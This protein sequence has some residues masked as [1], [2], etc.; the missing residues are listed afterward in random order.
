MST[1]NRNENFKNNSSKIIGIQFSILSPEEIKKGSVA[2]IT[3]RDTYINNKP[4]IGGLFDP[5]MG[6]IEPNLICPTDGLDYMQTPGYF[7]HIDLARPVFY[8][9]YLN[10]VIK[11]LRCICIKCSK[12]L[13][14]KEKY[15]ELENLLP[16]E[17]WNRVFS[18]AIKIK[19][20]G[21]CTD[22]GCGCKQPTK[23][24]KENLAT[25]IAEWNNVDK[26]DDGNSTLTVKLTPEKVIK[27]FRRISDDNIRFMGF[28]PIWS[29]PDWM[30]C[31]T[32]AIPPPAVRPSVKHD[33]QQR[34]ED[35]ITH[36]IFNIIKTNK[37]LQEKIAIN[38]SAV[39]IDEWTTVLQYFVATL[40]D[41]KIPGVASVAQ[42]S[43][44]PLKSIKERLNG[45]GGRVRGNLMGKRVDFS[46]RSVI[47]PDPQLS[48]RELGIPLKIAKNLT[49][50]VTVNDNNKNFLLK[51][52]RNGTDIYPG[53]KILEKDGKSI[54]LCFHKESIKLNN[55]DIV[56]RHMLD[57]DTILFNR[58]PTLHRMSMMAHTVV[59]MP[60][61][62]TFRMNVGDTKPYNADFDGDEMNLH[63]PQDEE[64]EIELMQ[65]AAIPTQIIS[66]ANNKS[67]IGIFQDSLLGCYLFSNEDKKY[68]MRF[69]MNLLMS[70]KQ[71]N[72][73]Q[74]AGKTKFSN[75][76]ILSQILPP[77][78]LRY[79]TKK[80]K[81]G[82][83]YK[84]S[85]SVL[86]IQ[87]G[88][89]VRGQ[90]EKG[91]L[92]DGG[93]GLLQRIYNDYGPRASA[94]FIDNIQNIVT[95]FMKYN[96]YSVGISDLISDSKTTKAIA[97]VIINKKNSVH[98]LIDETHLG[99]FENKTGKSNSDE[100]EN[101]VT[102]ILNQTSQETG[103]IGRN[104]LD[105]KNRFVIMV[106]AGSK[107]S[108]LNIAQM[109][110]CLGQ[111]SVD[112]KRIPYGFEN[113][114]LPHFSKF[115]D[116][117][118]ARGF[119]ENSFISGL[120]PTELFFHAIGGRV[121]LIDTAV[122]TSTTGYISR[123]LIKSLEDLMVHYDMTV[124]NNK[125]KIIQFKYG[126]DAFDPIKVENQLIPLVDMSLEEIYGYLQISTDKK[127]DS[128]MLLL[129]DAAKKL[130]TQQ[131]AKL[132]DKIQFYIEYMKVSQRE[133]INNVFKNIYNKQVNLPVAFSHIIENIV[134]QLNLTENS[135]VDITPYDAYLMIEATY[136]HLES[137]TFIKPNALFKVLYYYYLTPKQL[138]IIKHFNMKA[139]TQLLDT[140]V[141]MYKAAIVN[142]GE[143]VGIV[144]AQ[145]IGEPTTQLTL[146]SVTY[147][148]EI[149]VRNRAGIIKK[150]KIGEFTEANILISKKKEYY[151]DKDTM[152]AELN[153]FCEI[154]SATEEG[155][156]TWN[157][158]EAVTRHPVVNEDGTNTLIRVT[159][160]HGRDVTATKAKSF[161]QLRDGKIVGVDGKDL[162]V[163]DYLPVSRKPI[164][165]T[166]QFSVDLKNIFLP[167]EYLY[168]SEVEKGKV[169]M[170]EYH[171]WLKHHTKTFTVPYARSDSFREKT[172]GDIRA[173]CKSKWDFVSGCVYPFPHTG[174]CKSQIPESI[175]LDYDF[176]YLIGA[177]C[178]EGCVTKTQI[179]IANLELEYFEPIQ[180]LCQ[181]YNIT[182]K[183]YTHDDKGKVGW[184]SR[185]IRIY[186]VMLTRMV[187]LFGGRLSHGKKVHDRIIFSNKECLKGF[188]DA[189]IGGDGHVC[190]RGNEINVYSVSKDL[191][192]DVHQILNIL[193]IYSQVRKCKAP[194][195]D[196]VFPTYTTPL[197]NIKQGYTLHITNKQAHKLAS[198]LN[199]K[200][201]T[202]QAR[203][204]ITLAHNHKYEYCRNDLTVP[205]II[206][207]K[208]IMEP[209]D[210]RYPEIY[211]DKIK[212][213][214]EVANPTSHVYDLTVE[215]TR[216]FNIYNGLNLVDTFHFSGIAS[217]SN[218][219]RGVPRIEEIL[220]LSENP[221]NP[222]CT[223][224]LPKTLE[225]DKT[226]ATDLIKD[227]EHTKLRDV[228]SSITICF[229]PD[230]LNTLCNDDIETMKQFKEFSDVVNDC[231]E[232]KTANDKSKSKWIIRMEMNELVMLDKNIT[233]DDVHFA[234]TYSYPDTI[235]CVYSDYNSDKLVFRIRIINPALSKKKA[236]MPVS[237]DQSDEIHILKNFQDELLNNIILRGIKSLSKVNLRKIVDSVVE[238][239]GSYIKKEIWV[240]DTA[241]TNL[242]KV[243]A[244]NNIDV[245]NTVTNDIQE[246]YRTLGV[247][248]ARQSIYNELTE[249]IEFDSTYINYHHLSLLCDRMTCNK[250]LV[251]VFRHG[252]NNDDIGPIAK[253]SFEETPEQFLKAARH[254]EL[255]N[256][257]GIS[258]NV[259]CG[260]EGYFGT[261]CFKVLLDINETIKHNEINEYV[262]KNV[263]E[264][265]EK[266]FSDPND[267]C[268]ISKIAIQ[269]N[270]NNI[271]N[272]KLG[273]MDADYN[274][275]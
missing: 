69:A 160:E 46:A 34:S 2:E 59:I 136:A 257:R 103:K 219:T 89:F 214:E 171:W 95:E 5:R 212:S 54:S 217:K 14:S 180:R 67:I 173:G 188:L 261:N 142:P 41:N 265:N 271:K 256:M 80:F 224:Y 15:K 179:S 228:V 47:T 85:N 203:L 121:G 174:M 152:Y 50:P 60:E 72:V 169:V 63:M 129:T 102:N 216:N 137:Y 74:L 58:Q 176:G 238:S 12:L 154:P 38:A 128:I 81:D 163:G 192:W 225:H 220:S 133:I 71:I 53:A 168:T 255:D 145:S 246:I 100:F 245:N 150:V 268:G 201:E 91:V 226:A 138:L 240:L 98:S 118:G 43:G 147:D 172:S 210:G 61:G 149:I 185:D 93:K 3:T 73:D 112:G 113:R 79:K 231:L 237:L 196:V 146:N 143:M 229:D 125:N 254:G 70:I 198:M 116:S 27:L 83:D 99:I 274:P 170:H 222:S 28:S 65:L 144:A 182:T 164:D 64:S 135:L 119:V 190:K 75:F 213:I 11:I 9:Q 24:K 247:E 117:P 194:H 156:I 166:S 78:S 269:T 197:A 18:F 141:K 92:A 21:E 184:T 191:L 123:R 223:I 40:V 153:D 25:L 45:K 206:N 62:D 77:I 109:V 51:L 139:L 90:I 96:S 36:I 242:L 252:I 244:M 205:N 167:S 200:H 266:E 124:R 120:S 189:Y 187:E 55:G 111:Q 235:S 178:A 115:D 140:I 161:L 82:D 68:D 66:P 22:D 130:Y 114:T 29:R 253:A 44:R 6:V 251:S 234:L 127:D 270:V 97:D 193:G 218:V 148:T 31:Q 84:T 209:R 57:G 181:K 248:A 211:F 94:D 35:D 7:G 260:Q 175:E 132:N 250:N 258:A 8:I 202:K 162:K 207:G 30:I 267:A 106:N 32:L 199:M 263:D 208:L 158:I 227:L 88:K 159:T 259:L 13:I 221:K 37:T 131:K 275:F 86:E 126:D 195:K 20:C 48:I 87:N 1:T 134:G 239:N 107:G 23:I 151:S 264:Y 10:T 230:D 19:R 177:Y 249:V 155:E 273:Q 76:D 4:V 122:K 17:R 272:I 243:L 49:K 39:V 108:E 215:K 157:T 110:S 52:V 183:I 33:S 241:G 104:S 232:N 204:R 262:A 26:D 105:S 236:A 42:R 233:M 16:D 165:F 186:S 101:K 56:H